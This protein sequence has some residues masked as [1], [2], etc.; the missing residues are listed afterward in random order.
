M[1]K[2]IKEYADKF[3]SVMQ[4]FIKT[5]HSSSDSSQP[6]NLDITIGQCLVLQNLYQ[7]DNC[8]MSD[9]SKALGVTLPNITGLI[10]R[11]EK[12][13]LA[14]RNHDPKDRRIIRITLTTKGKKT[15]KKIK[16][17]KQQHLSSILGK[18]TN[19]ERKTLMEIMEKIAAKLKKTCAIVTIALLCSGAVFANSTLSLDEFIKTAVKNNPQYRISA[20]DYLI[21]LEQNKS[22]NSLQDWNLVASGY[23]NEANPPQASSFSPSYQKIA[24]YSF[25][26][27]KYLAASGTG[28]EIKNSNTRMAAN[29]GS[30]S[31][32]FPTSPYYTSNLSLTITQP[33]LR[34]A[35]GLATRNNLAMAD[36]ALSIAKVKL[37]EDWENFLTTLKEEYFK[38]QLCHL[39]ITN[40]Q[41]KVKKV[42]DQLALVKKQNRYGLSED[43]DLVQI[44][45]KLQGYKIMLAQAEMAC[46][47]QTEKVLGLIKKS[48]L[49][50]PTISP[51]KFVKDGTVLPKEQ[52][53]AYLLN[54]S[55]LKQTTDLLVKIQQQNLNSK[56]NQLLPDLNLIAQYKP[57]ALTYNFSDS[58]MRVGSKSEY[59][60]TLSASRTLA[61]DQANAEANKAKAEYEKVLKIQDNTL[62]NAQVGL[63]NLYTTLSYLDSM[64]ELNKQSL[65]L[66]QERLTLEQKKFNQGRSSVFF[67][68]QAEDDVL[69]ADNTYLEILFNREKVINQIKSFTDRYLI[70]YK[71]LLKI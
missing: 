67:V 39:N 35:F 27:S 62:L 59:S 17:K 34:N 63:T 57:N 42:E 2:N 51:E 19:K 43:L 29:Y 24:S 60:I 9:L 37:S 18:I 10:D 69:A 11:L 38:W 20:Q 66:A 50:D 16:Q 28:I 3:E 30:A 68:L 6:N 8:K 53:I 7:N 52:A 4:G 15:I 12:E 13:G 14:K 71:E 1:A 21:A 44:E 58:V 25:G 48:N 56:D 40:Y 64:L 45:Q 41:T 47:N 46:D 31:A 49:D 5:L 23:F 65:K 36:S 54:N 61:N 70:E 22:A 26:A 33:L 55:N 32:F